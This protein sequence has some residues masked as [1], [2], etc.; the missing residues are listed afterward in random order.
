LKA[1]IDYIA[2]WMESSLGYKVQS[3]V[4]TKST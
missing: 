3:P 4:V 1:S 2:I